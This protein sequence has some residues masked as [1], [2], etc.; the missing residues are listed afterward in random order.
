[1]IMR[2]RIDPPHPLVCLKWRLNGAVLRISSRYAF[3]MI[4][5][6][7]RQQRR[8]GTGVSGISIRTYIRQ[9]LLILID[10]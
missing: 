4:P 1:M 5:P 8:K 9:R 7:F 2:V 10:F 6:G 3:H